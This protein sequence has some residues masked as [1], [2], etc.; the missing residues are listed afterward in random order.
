MSYSVTFVPRGEKAFGKAK[1]RDMETYKEI[2][3]KIA[4]ILE[5]P[6]RFGKPMRS[7]YKGLWEIHVKNNLLYYRINEGSKSVEIV[8]YLDHDTL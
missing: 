4:K 2:A 7:E 5:D 1:K 6:Y 3:R 8:A